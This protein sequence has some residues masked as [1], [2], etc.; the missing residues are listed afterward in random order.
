MIVKRLVE[1]RIVRRLQ[2][3]FQK[4]L[5]QHFGPISLSLFPSS[6]HSLM[7]VS[8]SRFLPRIDRIQVL[9]TAIPV[10]LKESLTCFSLVVV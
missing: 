8:L 6:C 4:K 5:Q 7:P 1:K 2:P 10:S 9:V 3:T